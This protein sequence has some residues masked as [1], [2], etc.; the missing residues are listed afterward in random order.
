MHVCYM[1]IEWYDGCFIEYCNS[2]NVTCTF[3]MES[4]AILSLILELW[5]DNLATLATDWVYPVNIY[6]ETNCATGLQ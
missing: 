3:H 2:L 6:I 1:Y 4:S 5:W